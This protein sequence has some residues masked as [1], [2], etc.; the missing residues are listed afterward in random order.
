MKTKTLLT[1]LTFLISLQL[2]ASQTIV[3]GGPVEGFW[4]VDNSPYFIKGAIFVDD[5]K[6]LEIEAGVIVIFET[7]EPMIINGGLIAV[8]TKTDSIRFTADFHERGWGG[9]R[10]EPGLPGSET[11]ILS[12]CKFEYAIA[13]GEWPYH[14]GGAIGVRYVNDLSINNCLFE[15]NKAVEQRRDGPD[16]GGRGGAIAI[17]LSD[18][19]LSKNV[20]RYNEAINGGAIFVDKYSNAIID[21]SISTAPY[22][23]SPRQSPK[24]SA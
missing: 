18:I 12:Y 4:S 21:N 6:T 7:N 13:G 9:L 5:H 14:S 11:S 23:K 16:N 17:W 15:H 19:R 1:I 24:K 10:F 22:P 20:F 3:Y 2:T 8:G